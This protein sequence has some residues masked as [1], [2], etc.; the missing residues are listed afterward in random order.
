MPRRDHLRRLLERHN[1][2]DAQEREHQARILQLLETTQ[3]PFSRDQ[4]VPGHVTASAFVM[5]EGARELLLILHSKLGLWL[6]PGGHVEPEDADVLETARREVLEE[7]GVSALTVVG[8]GL[9][10]LDVHD[11]PARGLHPAHAHFDVRFLF[12]AADRAYRAG[13]D[14]KDAGWVPIAELLA[15]AAAPQ[16]AVYPSDESVMRAVRKLVQVRA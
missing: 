2:A 11:I 15:S 7:V 16:R 13:S 5:D 4:Y 6:Q 9:L 14:A 3:Q 8:T 12:T 10:D 1:P